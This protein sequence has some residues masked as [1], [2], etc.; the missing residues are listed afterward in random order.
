MVNWTCLDDPD[1]K[2]L[3]T[4]YSLFQCFDASG[5]CNILYNIY[6][7]ILSVHTVIKENEMFNNH[8]CNI[9]CYRSSGFYGISYFYTL[10]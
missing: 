5:P 7:V 1:I 8:K 10:K 4:V 3:I 9:S 2:D 6:K